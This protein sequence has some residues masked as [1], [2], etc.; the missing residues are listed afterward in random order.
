M[1]YLSDTMLA[2][3]VLL[4]FPDI[5]PSLITSL[6]HSMWFH[7]PVKADK[8]YL[9]VFENERYNECKSLTTARYMYVMS[10]IHVHYIMNKCHIII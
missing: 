2:G 10:C 6:D 7:S 4:K 5:K 1:S 3:M 9:F 8:W